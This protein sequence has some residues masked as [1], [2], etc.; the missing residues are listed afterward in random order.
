MKKLLF[1]LLS[2]SCYA[3]TE[4]PNVLMI[5][6]DDL[7]DYIGVL[8]G[9]PQT[10]TPNIDKL[11]NDGILFTNAHSNAPVC[12]PSRA[13]FMSGILP[14]TSKNFGFDNWTK[15]E[16][17]K[18]SKI[19]PEYFSENGYTTYKTGKV[20]H[21]TK[22]E[23]ELWDH[24]L[25]NSLDYGPMA[26]DGND[27][28][29]HPNGN[30]SYFEN[31]GPLDATIARL[32]DIPNV[33]ADDTN[34]GYN[35]WRWH[36]GAFSYI[37]ADNRDPMPD[38][39]SAHWIQ[40]QL[41]NLEN[42]D[43]TDSF[44]MALGLVR[45]HTPLVVPDKY[46][47]MFP[48]EEV[49]IPIIRKNDREDTYFT[50]GEK[51]Y[52]LFDILGNE[53]TDRQEGLRRKTQAY[54]AAVAF[55]DDMVG[56]V[57]STLENSIYNDNTVV[58]LF[59]DHGF[60]I[61]E[62]QYLRKNTLWNEATRV[63]LI[64]KSPQHA[65]YAG[66]SVDHPVSLIDIYPTL[67]E[68]CGLT[69]ATKKNENGADIDGYSLVPFLENPNSTDWEG[70]HT[71]LTSVGIWGTENNNFSVVSKR[72]RYTQYFSGDEE[73][74]DHFYDKGE[75]LN[76]AD[77]PAYQ[78][79]K[80]LLKKELQQQSGTKTLL[81]D[82]LIDFS[83]LH[84]KSDNWELKTLT[85]GNFIYD[86][87]QIV[88]TNTEVGTITYKV[89]NLDSFRVDLFGIRNDTPD[90]FGSIRAF[91]A[92]TDEVYTEIAVDYYTTYNSGWRDIFSYEPT[93]SIPENT[94]YIRFELSSLEGVPAW[95]ALI[96]SVYLYV[97]NN[98]NTSEGQNPDEL[99]VV[100]D[101]S[102]F[103]LSE[104][105]LRSNAPMLPFVSD[106]LIDDSYFHESSGGFYFTTNSTDPTLYDN[107]VERMVRPNNGTDMSVSY[108]VGSLN[109]FRV[110]FYTDASKSIAQIA[111]NYGDLKF[112]RAGNDKVFT[113]IPFEFIALKTNETI[114]KYA[115]VPVDEITEDTHYI[116][117]EMTGGSNLWNAQFGAI[118]LYGS[119]EDD[120]SV[121]PPK[122]TAALTLFPN[123]ARTTLSIDGLSTITAYSIISMQ[124]RV[125]Q[126][127][128]TNGE[129]EVQNLAP[130]MY[131]LCLENTQ[132]IKFI[133]K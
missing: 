103:D 1:F 32:S 17:L 13:S 16:V 46:F 33:P 20:T 7:N 62:K 77:Y 24:L 52:V 35:G 44:F 112:Y 85:D 110:E 54:L 117:M 3:Q 88:R 125:Q 49:Q 70:P 48:L 129:I 40:Q 73:L 43:S 67:Q 30:I 38:E 68:L 130:G 31:S 12:A 74:Y 51:G 57:M 36:Q 63:P 113:E 9:H 15:N 126:K 75:W 86:T 80:E 131:L 71:A 123:P 55:A 128:V 81:K 11:A 124:G 56:Q 28:T 97:E 18:N 98:T 59:S 115:L 87:D 34:P 132:P 95:K 19:L 23:S 58:M 114:K 21:G 76:V 91:A 41:T 79:V 10:K 127:G 133:K 65:N 39:N 94:E 66:A 60:H 26:Y 107:D 111:S 99:A 14:I 61:G 120:L 78:T 50:N 45:P 83:Q 90:D 122:E 96:A 104:S 5:V 100:V 22:L 53:Y 108:Q 106:P 118:H 89:E 101:P 82:P 93:V 69:G 4:K 37:D 121:A 64:I 25:T 27:Y 29:M 2:I 42:I 92:G 47:D 72:Y 109:Y 102:I 116:K 119:A 8:E 84:E 105:E 6:L